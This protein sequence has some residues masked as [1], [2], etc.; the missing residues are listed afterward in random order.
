[1]ARGRAGGQDGRIRLEVEVVEDGGAVETRVV[2]LDLGGVGRRDD[3]GRLAILWALAFAG[4]TIPALFWAN[5]RRPK[6]VPLP[7]NF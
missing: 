1:M 2:Q 5:R 3:G 6:P 4:A 7:R